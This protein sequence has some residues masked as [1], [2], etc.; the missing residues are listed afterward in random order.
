VASI[1]IMI[2]GQFGLTWARWQNILTAAEAF[3]YQCVFRSD[4]YTIGTPAEESLETFVSLTY[5][6][7]HTQRIEFGSLV[8]PTTFRHPALTARMAAGI[9]D[10]SGGRLVLGLGVGWNESEHSQFGIPFPDT[11]T[12]YAMFIDALEVTTR[13][14]RSE[15]PISYNGAHYPLRDAILLPRP[16]RPGGP[17]VLIGGNGPKRTLPLAAKYAAE[18]NGVFLNPADY[19]QRN[20]LLNELLAQEDRAPES[21]KRSLMT[22]VVFGSTDAEVQRKLAGSPGDEDNDAIIVGTASQVIDRIGA[23]VEAGCERFMLQW[24]ALDDID[25]LERMARDVLPAFHAP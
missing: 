15:T 18:W 14:Y 24:L 20:L 16:Q 1:G 19:R 6:A 7:Q 4:H 22:K 2:E 12:R 8:A 11:D 25:G 13:L 21:L 9:D 23:Y 10:L 3:G 5:A 17:P